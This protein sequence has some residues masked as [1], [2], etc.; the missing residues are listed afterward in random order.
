MTFLLSLSADLDTISVEKKTQN[1][2]H[3]SGE[4]DRKELIKRWNSAQK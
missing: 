1:T 3:K 2:R 4:D